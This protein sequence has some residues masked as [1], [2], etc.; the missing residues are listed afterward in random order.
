M[1]EFT[2]KEGAAVLKPNDPY[3]Q[4]IQGKLYGLYD[5]IPAQ[6]IAQKEPVKEKH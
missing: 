6:F 5:L 1:S 3:F 2:M 4:K